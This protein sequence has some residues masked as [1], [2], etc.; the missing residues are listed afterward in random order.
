MIHNIGV[1]I[2]EVQRIA[3]AQ[4]RFGKRFL[5]RVFTQEELKYCLS[6]PHPDQ[7]LAARFAAKEAVIKA[8]RITRMLH[9]LKCIEVVKDEFTG[10]PEIRLSGQVKRVA[11][12][13]NISSLMV[14]LSHTDN[15][16]VAQVVCLLGEKYEGL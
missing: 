11:D 14:S 15:Y 9:P 5:N 3:K 2:V 13:L 7:H 8:L 16:A 12:R 6:R 4:K 1:D 10:S